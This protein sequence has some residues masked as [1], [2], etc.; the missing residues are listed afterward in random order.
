MRIARNI[1]LVFL[2]LVG[3]FVIIFPRQSAVIVFIIGGKLVAPEASAV[4]AHYCFGNGDTLHLS[5]DYLRRSTVVLRSIRGLKEGEVRRIVFKQQDD[6]RLSYALNPFHVKKA[7]GAYVI[8]Q[9][10]VFASDKH[11]FTVL[12]LWLTK[13]IVPDNIVHVFD[14]KPFVAVSRFSL[15]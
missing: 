1:V 4:L 15:P 2:L 3:L 7:G 11:T 8:F 13:L 14:C 12:D 10:I 5:P 9:Q 6:W